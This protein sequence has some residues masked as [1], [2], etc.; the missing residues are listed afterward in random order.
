MYKVSNTF[1]REATPAR[2]RVLNIKF[3]K[4]PMRLPND[5]RP[6]FR[7]NS[8]LNWKANAAKR[9]LKLISIMVDCRLT[10]R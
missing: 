10:K 6:S 1:P 7:L 5:R 4:K 3:Q 9:T 8:Q 2:A